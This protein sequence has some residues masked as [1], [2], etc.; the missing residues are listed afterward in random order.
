M[1]KR[2]R[3]DSIAF[4]LAAA[5]VVSAVIQSL[6]MSIFLIVGGVIKQSEENAYMIFSENVTGRAVSIENEMDYVWTNFEHYTDEIRRYFTDLNTNQ[7]GREK[8]V[9]EILGDLAPIVLDALHYTKTTGTFLILENE[10]GTG[11]SHD[12][13]Y[14]RNSNPNQKNEKNTNIFLLAG[15]WNVAEKMNVVTDHS[16]SFKLKLNEKNRNFYEKPFDCIGLSGDARLL[17]YWSPP[18]KLNSE[19]E[20]V[21]TYS[22]PLMDYKGRPIGVFGVEIS[23][24]YLYRFL[25]SD[26][27]QTKN[28]YGYIF[29][30][31]V[32]GNENKLEVM[33]SHGA[34]Q[35]RT[36][37][38][39]IMLELIEVDKAK[40]I[41]SLD[42]EGVKD[43]LYICLERLGMY[44]N[45][46]P[47]SGEKWYLIGLVDKS[48]LLKYTE[49][50]KTL[51][52]YSLVTTLVF[53]TII[54]VFIS[55]W[56]TK[57]SKLIELSEVPVGVFEINS[58][59]HKVYMTNQ[60]PLLLDLTKEQERSFSKNKEKF[61]EFLE[62][63]CQS[64]IDEVSIFCLKVFNKE[65]WLR[66]TQKEK[67]GTVIG[68]VQDVT[69]EFRRTQILKTER[70]SDGLTGVKNRMAFEYFS[71]SYPL[72]ETLH[73]RLAVVMCD[74]N[75]LKQ[76]NDTFGHEKGDQY[77][78][79]ASSLICASFPDGQVFRIGGDEF[80]VVL[81]DATEEKLLKS[82]ALMDASMREYGAANQFKADIAWG[83]AF[84]NRKRD[85]TIKDILS[86]ADLWMYEDKKKKKNRKG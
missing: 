15:P 81:D 77:I 39:G 4:K 85:A 45:N 66:I 12:A 65:R 80:A 19:G 64:R 44:Y 49:D 14:F 53:G 75:Q 13:L 79:Y 26:D 20:E 57:N 11:E 6:L 82:G 9:N 83:Y 54:A 84:Y 30:R 27:S 37:A 60:I 51:L 62:M 22:I 3:S 58:R 33:I 52:L 50:I 43:K 1:N 72:C 48:A 8:T 78:S 61:Q 47:F 10:D 28:A 63:V 70:D 59:S 76:V 67:D 71:Q 38:R 46:T 32:E 74:L 16:W 73:G 68:I 25:P 36:L 24:D 23:I 35:N 31:C 42:N 5:F 17:G 40:G 69:D 34:L 2:F 18:F 86:R 21:I 55:K 56:F 41:Y 7:A 29:G